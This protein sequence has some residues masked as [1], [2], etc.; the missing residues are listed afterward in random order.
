MKKKMAVCITAYEPG[1]QSVVLEETTRR[2][3]KYYD[4]DLYCVY[5]KKLKPHWIN[6]LYHVKPW[7]NKLT[8]LSNYEFI[9]SLKNYDIIHC[10]DSIGFMDCAI[11]SEVKT[12]V[13]AHGIYPWKYLPDLNRKMICLLSEIFYKYYYRKIKNIVAISQFVKDW[14]KDYANVDSVLIYNGFSPEKFHKLKKISVLKKFNKRDPK[15]IFAGQVSKRKGIDLIIKAISLLKEE[16]PEIILAIAG[17]DD[18]NEAKIFKEQ[19]VSSNLEKNIIFLGN[20]KHE[21]LINYYNWGD[22]FITA[23]RV[24]GFGVPIIESVACGTPAVGYGGKGSAVKEIIEGLNYG[25]VFLD[26]NPLSL[27]EAILRC[28]HNKKKYKLNKDFFNRLN[29]DYSSKEYLKLFKR[30][31]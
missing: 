19:V 25:E 16:Y 10:H 29:W 22:I 2:F 4:I 3:A 12:I 17:H 27:K 11:K 24:E 26:Y 1:G 21:N 14:L 31:N 8:P 23:S 28:I 13:T 7:P 20:I 9:E 6:N 30:A 5:S 15:L 18:S